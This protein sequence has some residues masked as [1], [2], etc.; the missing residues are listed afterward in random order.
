MLLNI[1]GTAACAVV[2]DSSWPYTARARR[3]SQQRRQP[4]KIAGPFLP[5]VYPTVVGMFLLQERMT[6]CTRCFVQRETSSIELEHENTR[7]GDLRTE[8]P[9][10]RQ[11]R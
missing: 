4:A 10:L 5:H 8:I 1:G 3:P 2:S 6:L 11:A 9:V 7:C